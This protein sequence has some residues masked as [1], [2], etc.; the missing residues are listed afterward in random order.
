[1]KKIALLLSVFFTLTAVAQVKQTVT[2]SNVIFRIKNM[3]VMTGG[4]FNGLV[5]DI[6][7]DPA[8]LSASSIDAFVD[9]RTIDTDN[10]LRDNHLKSTDYFDVDRYPK[11]SMKS[12]SFKHKRA[13]NYTGIFNVTIKNKTKTVEVP[14]TYTADGSVA[15]FEGSFRINRLDFGIGD[16]SM[17]L[18]NEATVSIKL[19]TA[20]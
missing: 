5:A 2:K 4:S 20:K 14:F 13:G 19:E 17:V 1:M 15:N 10:G 8:N 3:G 6:K 9:A 18:S 11:I 7:F 16:T 12:V